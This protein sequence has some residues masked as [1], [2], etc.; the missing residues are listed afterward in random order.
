MNGKTAKKLRRQAFVTKIPIKSLKRIWKKV[1]VTHKP[2]LNKLM[3]R[4]A[5]MA[6]QAR[7]NQ[8]HQNVPGRL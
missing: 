7:D 1:P 5:K 8:L 2:E 6:A 3:A 4:G